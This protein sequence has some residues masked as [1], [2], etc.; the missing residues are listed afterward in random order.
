MTKAKVAHPFRVILVS[1]LFLPFP[2]A[3]AGQ[4]EQKRDVTEDTFVAQHR[5]AARKNPEGVSF[6][7]R[8]EEDRS[9]FKPGEVIR[10]EFSFT[11]DLPD[12]YDLEGRTYDRGGRLQLDKFF[13][14]HNNGVADPLKDYIFGP[15]GGI[16]P[17][18]PPLSEKPYKMTFDLNEWFRFDQPGRFRLYVVSPRVRKKGERMS[19][20]YEEVTSNIVEFEI[21]PRD[22]DWAEQELHSITRLLDSSDQKMDRRAVCRRL[23]FLNTEAAANE[24]IRRFG[25]PLNVCGYE[26]SMGLIGSAYRA[27]VVMEMERRL[28]APDQIVSDTYLYTLSHVATSLHRKESL[29]SPAE[30]PNDERQAKASTETGIN[31]WE[32]SQKL[33][34]QYTERL[35]LALPRKQG[36]ARA[37]A[38][39]TLLEK[40]WNDGLQSNQPSLGNPVRTGGPN[41]EIIRKLAPEI[42]AVF[43]DLPAN[44]QT[45]LLGYRW[46]YVAG[47]AMLP[48]IHRILNISNK[49]ANDQSYESKD[50]RSLALRRLYEMAPDEGRKLII[51]ELR[52]PSPSVGFAT[53][54]LLP[55][56][57]LPDLD[58]TLVENLKKAL[59]AAGGNADMLSM[60]IE[61]YATASVAPQVRDIYGSKGGKWACSIQSALLAYFLRVDAPTGIELAK[62]ALDARGTED[63]HCYT[64]LLSDVAKLRMTPELE[65]LAIEHLDDPDPEVVISA[66]STLGQYGSTDAEKPLWARLEKWL[67][68]WKERAEELPKNLDTNNPNFWPKQVATSLRQALSQSPAWLID[69]EELERLRQSCLD[70]DELQQ[71]NYQVGDLTGKILITFQP[72]DEGWGSATVAHYQCNSLSALM[73]KLSQFP[74]NTTF[75]WTSYG[76]DQ[77]AAERVF[78]E[79]KTSIEGKGM[80]LEKRKDQ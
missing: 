5:E 48:V 22:D 30:R 71:F 60:L 10:V 42:I 15:G 34:A 77:S 39:H 37:I 44:L 65:T 8:L 1:L 52:R 19:I 43:D 61:S 79:L 78:A 64:A 46:K 6:T 35:M 23:R 31:Q 32:S 25:E 27:F 58:E 56:E 75:T 11:S 55:D 16:S 9:Q 50:L 73:M 29:P 80:K 40:L 12:T 47:P 68:E 28:E 74:K 18:P 2:L 20:N 41:P 51:E 72:G 38:A 21:L 63:S 24:M 76:Q 33:Q 3:V 62:Q 45:G 26:Y 69:H 14:D 4:S 70:K 66:A 59:S 7:L 13:L 67:Q 17:V 49:P 36:K 54:K 57:T 53:L